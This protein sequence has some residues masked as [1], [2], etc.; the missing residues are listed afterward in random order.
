M[1]TDPEEIR[2]LI[3]TMAQASPGWGERRI[4]GEMLK[5]GYRISNSTIRLILRQHRRLSAALPLAVD[6]VHGPAVTAANLVCGRIRLAS[7]RAG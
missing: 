2:D 1:T 3:L 5:L 7:R 4:Q 6:T